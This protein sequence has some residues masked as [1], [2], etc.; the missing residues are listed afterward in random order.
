MFDLCIYV[1]IFQDCCVV[2][3]IV[4]EESKSTKKESQKGFDLLS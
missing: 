1:Y 4:N 2:F 3:D